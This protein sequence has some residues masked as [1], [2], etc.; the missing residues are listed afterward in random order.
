MASQSFVGHLQSSIIFPFQ[1]MLEVGW[2]FKLVS[3]ESE[4][5]HVGCVEAWQRRRIAI[6][7]LLCWCL[8]VG[9]VVF[10]LAMCG[11]SSGVGAAFHLGRAWQR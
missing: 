5:S 7:L 6:F 1:N 10:S 3:E 2:R 9:G 4:L 8:V 11:P